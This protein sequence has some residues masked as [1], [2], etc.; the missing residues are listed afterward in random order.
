M[1]LLGIILAL[2]SDFNIISCA[3]CTFEIV[4][5][6]FS[7]VHTI[8]YPHHFNP[9]PSLTT[10]KHCVRFSLPQD[11]CKSIWKHYHSYCLKIF[12]ENVVDYSSIDMFYFLTYDNPVRS[13]N[14]INLNALI[15][16]HLTLPEF[17]ETITRNVDVSFYTHP[18]DTSPRDHTPKDVYRYLLSFTLDYTAPHGAF[19]EFGSYCGSSTRIIEEYFRRLGGQD[20]L[21]ESLIRMDSLPILRL[22]QSNGE[23]DFSMKQFHLSSRPY[24]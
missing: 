23:L 24:H 19:L 18:R 7:I 14:P 1:W 9:L 8:T 4:Y 12:D 3:P 20:F 5:K 21:L 6:D 16:P 13:R 11:N 2:I 15:S 10:F 17:I 22:I